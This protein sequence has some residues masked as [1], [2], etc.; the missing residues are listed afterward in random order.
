MRGKGARK[1]VVCPEMEGN[2]KQEAGVRG[3]RRRKESVMSRERQKWEEELVL[4]KSQEVFYNKGHIL[5][6]IVFR[7]KDSDA[8][9]KGN[10]RVHQ[11]R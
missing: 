2:R 5:V 8:S 6:G 7:V 10:W 1:S 11:T 4:V 9:I 3:M